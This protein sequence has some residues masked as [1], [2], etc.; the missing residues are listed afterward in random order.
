MVIRNKNVSK[1]ATYKY[2]KQT[3]LKNLFKTTFLFTIINL[4]RVCRRCR[5]NGA[6]IVSSGDSNRI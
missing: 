3:Y 4:S 6:S 2:K 5:N 1:K